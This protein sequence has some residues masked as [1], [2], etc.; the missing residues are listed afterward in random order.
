[1][2]KII[3]KANRQRSLL[4]RHPWIFSGAIE[5]FDPELSNGDPACVYDSQGHFL[6]MAHFYKST[7]MARI[8]T[9]EQEE[10]NAAF[11]Q[12]RI[13]RAL[14]C[15]LR[16]GYPDERTTMYRLVH[17]EGDDLPGLII[18]I[19][20]RLAVMQCHTEGMWKVADTI[21]SAL[22]QLPELS[23]EAV[24]LK[25]AGEYQAGQGRFL[26]GHPQEIIVRENNIQFFIDCVRG[27]KTGF[28]IDQRDNRQLL[29]AFCRD[30]TVLNLFAYSGGF[31]LYAFK[32]GAARVVSVDSSA[33]ACEWNQINTE[34]NFGQ[35][36]HEIICADVEDY[37]RSCRTK[38]DIIIA[39]PPA[40]AKQR[41][42]MKAA[43]TKYRTLNK[44]LLRLLNPS[45][46]LFTFSCSQA[47]SKE[48]FQTVLF[49]SSLEAERVTK[50]L[51]RLGQPP[52]HPVSIFHPE[53][54][55]L[56]GFVLLA[57]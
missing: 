33:L 35:C 24:Y 54:D 37:L 34:L 38:F 20:G 17:A 53:G 2:R 57:D 15:R 46:M 10:I 7:I 43:E 4:Q 47:V 52:D 42:A 19:Y 41:M 50:I 16:L 3:L 12:R 23:L 32:G 9:F 27:Q 8:L 48:R 1:M 28:Y 40:Y 31:S 6:A 14:A 44:T 13:A 5:W 22:H 21:A 29:T 55:Y 49:K 11:F 36:P 25:P 18:D 39:D 51:Y 56:K 26:S 30:K 45:G